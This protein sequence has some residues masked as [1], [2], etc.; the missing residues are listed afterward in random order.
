MA[1]KRKLKKAVSAICGELFAECVAIGMNK[2]ETPR[3]EL[4]KVMT[5]ILM[6]EDDMMCGIS[7]PEPGVPPRKYY[8]ALCGDLKKRVEEIVDRLYAFA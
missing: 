6:L 7:S 4:D 1:S 5:D 2:P 3:E 8:R